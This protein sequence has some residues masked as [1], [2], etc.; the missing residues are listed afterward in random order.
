LKT[1]TLV[2][3]GFEDIGHCKWTLGIWRRYFG[4]QTLVISSERV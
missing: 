4:F 3:C 1:I 2:D